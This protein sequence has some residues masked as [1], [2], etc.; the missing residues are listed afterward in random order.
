MRDEAGK[1]TAI[2]GPEYDAV[3]RDALRSV[4]VD[5]GVSMQEVSWG[6]GGSQE[7]ET[8]IVVL[9]GRKLTVEAETYV[10]L[11]IT[12]DVDLVTAVAERVAERLGRGP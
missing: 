1:R 11:S 4:L 7:I 9:G 6:V 5:L 3:T 8:V 2:L 10:G 12:G